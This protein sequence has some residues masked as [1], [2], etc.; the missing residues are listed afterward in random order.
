MLAVSSRGARYGTATCRREGLNPL[1][2]LELGLSATAEEAKAAY[3]R[4]AK[5]H[6]P[7]LN[8]GDPLAADRFSAVRNAYEAFLRGEHMAP[9][10][11]VAAASTGPRKRRAPQG[12]A[13][14][15]SLRG[16][17]L[18]LPQDTAVTAR[19]LCRTCRGSGD[20]ACPACSIP[21]NPFKR[22]RAWVPCPVCG[23]S[24]P[25]PVAVPCPA[26]AGSAEETVRGTLA[27]SLHGG[28]FE[29][30]KVQV[31]VDSSHVELPLAVELPADTT[32]NGRDLCIVHAVAAPSLASGQR[33]V[34]TAPDGWTAQFNIPARSRTGDTVRI[35]NRGIPFAP[36][37]RGDLVIRL[38]ELRRR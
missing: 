17:L 34:L 32:R 3:R 25:M 36:G 28:S 23:A 7:D 4:L 19:I 35:E 30:L 5:L 16:A 10:Q 12:L 2:T 13:C 38:K 6:H 26:C 11:T 22:L 14:M 21:G 18:G 20:G 24:G 15:V 8:P 9:E 37:E 29:G 27:E 33:C 31:M 1:A